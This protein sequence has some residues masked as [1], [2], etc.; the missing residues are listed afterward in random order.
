MI[1]AD[2]LGYLSIEGLMKTPAGSM[3]GFCNA[4]FTGSYPLDVP[5]EANKFILDK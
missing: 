3:C 2:S 1:G 5:D 4:C